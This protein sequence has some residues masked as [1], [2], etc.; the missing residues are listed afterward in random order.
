MS[1]TRLTACAAVLGLAIAALAYLRDPPWL[2][3]MESGFRP[4]QTTSD[5]TRYRSMAGHASFFVPADARA[6]V[7]PSRISFADRL[8]PPVEVSIAIDDRRADAFVLRDD[9]WSRTEV[10]LPPP[11]RRQLRRIDIRVDRLRPGLRGADIGEVT[12]VR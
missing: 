3:T 8:D 9:R 1:S 10:R 4:W 12:I 5:G 2:A 7:I 11:G 6:V